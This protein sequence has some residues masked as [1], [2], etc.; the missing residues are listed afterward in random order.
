MSWVYQNEEIEDMANFTG[1]SSK[2]ATVL[3]SAAA[4]YLFLDYFSGGKCE[5]TATMEGKTVLITGCNTGIG[6]V[7]YLGNNGTKIDLP[8]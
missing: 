2:V 7:Q 5:S 1:V 3:G 6:N 4:S 8:L